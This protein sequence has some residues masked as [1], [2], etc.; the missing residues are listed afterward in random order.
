[1]DSDDPTSKPKQIMATVAVLLVVVL[2]VFGAK[3]F[4]RDNKRQASNTVSS[5]SDATAAGTLDAGNSGNTA[6]STGTYKDG[7][8]SVSGEYDSPG[9]MQSVGV[10]LTIQSGKVSAATVTEQATDGEAKEYQREFISG[11]K[12]FVI[13]KDINSIHLTQVSG[14]SLTSQGFN[15][16]LEQIK[17]QAQA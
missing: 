5:H 1:M 6:A 11:Y 3:A 13:G 8:Y 10:Q 17:D 2:V 15:D 9:G 7:T 16:A 12:T 4:D 14:S